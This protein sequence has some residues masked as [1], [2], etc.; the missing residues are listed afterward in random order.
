MTAQQTATQLTRLITG[1]VDTH[2]LVHHAA[3]V[4]EHQQPV[5]DRAF[6]ATEAGYLQLLDWMASGG[7]LGRVGVEST[8]SYGAGLA[9]FLLA[10]GVE[11]YEIQR[12]EKTSR[13]RQGKSDALDAYSAARQAAT[14]TAHGRLLGLPKTSTGI[15][16]AIRMIKI[17]RDSAVKQR[18][19]AYGQLRDLATTA[20]TAIHD[21]LIALTARQRVKRAAG[22][23][24]DPS[25]LAD[26]VQAA[27]RGLRDLAHRIQAL[28]AEITAAD[29][30]LTALT[31]Q[32]VPSLLAMR[33]I[34]TQT[35]A[36]LLLTAGQNI[37]RMRTEATF[38][39]LCGVAPLPASSGKTTT[40][41][42]LNRGGDR[43][44][45]S[46]LHM[47]I[48][49][50]IKD[51]PPTQAYLQQRLATGKTKPETIRCL[52]RHLARSIYRA[53]RNDLATT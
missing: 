24:P 35:A 31:H 10:A 20:P 44:A 18:T 34:G 43:Q 16:E 38:A 47:I 14:G 27:K 5:A 28:D 4:D 13:Y 23:R 50:R 52:K 33:Q 22:Y 45:N 9:R 15:V 21:D 25:R 3:I 7:L 48:I 51:H 6:P 32:A 30:D 53:L 40:R 29:Q 19:A 11:V 42:R 37:T 26:P 49:G 1:G 8:G 39:K 36:Q 46:A 2:Q 41:H 17:P 12:P